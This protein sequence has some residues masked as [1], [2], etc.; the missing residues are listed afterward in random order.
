MVP[1]IEIKDVRVERAERFIKEIEALQPSALRLAQQFA[2]DGQDALDIVQDS[3]LKAWKHWDEYDETRP[4]SHWFFRI[5]KNTCLDWKRNA[6]QRLRRPLTSVRGTATGEEISD[7][8]DTD[9]VLALAG[10]LPLRQRMVFLLKYQEDLDVHDIA[11]IMDI[12][13]DTVRVHLMKSRRR[14]REWYLK[15]QEKKR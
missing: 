8:S 4:F 10:R 2:R 3:I 5:L 11:E 12:S 14:I 9:V 7:L 1:C 6:Y 13:E 15:M